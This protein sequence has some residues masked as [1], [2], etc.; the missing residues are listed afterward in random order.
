[1]CSIRTIDY[2]VSI[3]YDGFLQWTTTRMI[4]L[5][6]MTLTKPMVDHC[7]N[8][9]TIELYETHK[10]DWADRKLAQVPLFLLKVT[11]LIAGNEDEQLQAPYYYYCY[12]YYY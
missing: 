5:A 6:M 9:A 8:D 10:I 1:M 7:D 2:Y 4:A 11:M 12:Y 3:Y